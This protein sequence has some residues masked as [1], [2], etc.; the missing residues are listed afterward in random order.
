MCVSARL[1]LTGLVV[2]CALLVQDAHA[3]GTLLSLPEFELCRDRFKQWKFNG[4]WYHFSWDR[5]AWDLNGG[6]GRIQPATSGQKVNWLEARNACRKRCMDAVSMESE[7]EDLMVTKFIEN[8]NVTYIWT[9]GRLCDFEGCA[10]R[11]DLQPVN[12]KGWF[13]SAVNRKISPTNAPTPGWSRNPQPWSRTGHHKR[14]QPDNAEFGINKTPESCLGV[15]N[16]LYQDG[17]KWHDIACYHK[18][19]YICED[20][21][22]LLNFIKGT[23]RDRIQDPNNF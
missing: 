15:L 8:R 16:N 17:I 19:P 14:P 21:E 10:E 4:K 23:N 7:Q 2:V 1:L 11:A 13:W 3:Q 20:N 6:Q 5:E 22:A 18:K 9:S 12:E